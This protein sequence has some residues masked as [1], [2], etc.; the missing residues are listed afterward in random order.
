MSL[1]RIQ[2]IPKRNRAEPWNTETNIQ[3]G[4]CGRSSRAR[5]VLHCDRA[6]IIGEVPSLSTGTRDVLFDRVTREGCSNGGYRQLP[7]AEQGPG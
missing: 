7:A 6:T 1:V 2:S 5:L 3:T 4:Q